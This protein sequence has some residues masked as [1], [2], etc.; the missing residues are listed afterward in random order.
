MSEPRVSP[1]RKIPTSKMEQTTISPEL[2]RW[3]WFG[4]QVTSAATVA[5]E[6]P[7]NDSGNGGLRGQ[8]PKVCG[9]KVVETYRQI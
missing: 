7:G 2:G 9:Q 4:S 5:L 8:G 6:Q 3:L 1:L